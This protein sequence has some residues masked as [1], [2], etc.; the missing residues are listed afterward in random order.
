MQ[1]QIS[2][3]EGELLD[4][5]RGVCSSGWWTVRGEGVHAMFTFDDPR[6]RGTTYGISEE[7]AL[8]QA[9]FFM[10]SGLMLEALREVVRVLETENPAIVDTVWVTGGRPETLRD[11][12]QSAI[13]AAEGKQ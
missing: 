13:H 1:L 6:D 8:A 10:A 11:M 7:R 12:V 2:K 5:E 9:R 3:R 4:A